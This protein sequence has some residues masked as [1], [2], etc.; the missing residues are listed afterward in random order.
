MAEFKRVL[1]K[2]SGEALGGDDGVGFEAETLKRIGAEIVEIGKS[3]IQVAVVMGAGNFFR[4][5]KGVSAGLDRV[6]SDQ[7]GMVGTLMNALGLK[8]AVDNSGGKSAVL[9]AFNSAPIAERY[10]IKYAK[11]YLDGNTVALLAGGTG[12]PFFTTDTAAVLRALELNCEVV[13]KASKV[14]GVYDSDPYKISV[15]KRFDKISYQE[16]L[17]KNLGVMDL[18][19]VTLAS[20]N[21]LPLV[22]FNLRDAGAMVKVAGGNT[23]IGTVIS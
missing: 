22:V 1:L 20:E 11:S 18:T 10:S 17:D 6:L 7:I 3:G 16:V 14:D 15:A 19:A 21:D 8:A 12:N 9:T 13:L 5:A 4:G 2:I 23:E